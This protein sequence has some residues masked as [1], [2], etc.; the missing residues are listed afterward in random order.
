MH[1]TSPI[2]SKIIYLQRSHFLLACWRPNLHPIPRRYLYRDNEH[3]IATGMV[4]VIEMNFTGKDI[5][6]LFRQKTF[7]H[8]LFPY[9]GWSTIVSYIAILRKEVGWAAFHKTAWLETETR[10]DETKG[11]DGKPWNIL[12]RIH[13]LRDWWCRSYSL[14]SIH[15]VS[16]ESGI[17]TASFTDYGWRL[18]LLKISYLAENCGAA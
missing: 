9:S 3:L 12:S 10:L 13:E 18:L 2:A 6:L 7:S 17:K 5:L 11:K 15:E 14:T 1:R 16:G 4:Q 8:R